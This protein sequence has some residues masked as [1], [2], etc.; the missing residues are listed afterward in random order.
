MRQPQSVR[1]PQPQSMCQSP[2]VIKL[3]FV[4]QPQSALGL[5]AKMTRAREEP[6]TGQ[7]YA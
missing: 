4:R 7:N 3:Q 6:K 2:Y 1:Q 5:G